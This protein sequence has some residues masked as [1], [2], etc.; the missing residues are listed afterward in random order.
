MDRDYLVMDYVP[1]KDLSNLMT[2]ARLKNRFLD[3]RDVLSWAGQLSEALSYLHSQE[4]PIVHRDIKPSNLKLTP[5]G[6]IK[7][8]DFGLVKI[9]AS[10]DEVTTDD[11]G[12]YIFTGLTAGTYTVSVSNEDYDVKP[13]EVEKE[14]TNEN[15]EDVDFVMSTL[16]PLVYLNI[17]P[18]GT[19]GTYINIFGLN[20]GEDPE[21]AGNTSTVTIGQ[22]DVSLTPGVYIGGT[23]P[24]K[25]IKCEIYSW[26][27]WKIVAIA[28]QAFGLFNVWVVQPTEDGGSTACYISEPIISNIY[29]SY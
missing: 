21:E 26:E 6:V 22:T 13:E 2:A 19:Q 17:P 29:F 7:L 12:A 10:S 16:C 27:F 18:V 23:N 11:N 14:I 8:V 25:W 5:D 24:E 15:I 20:F 9:L 3:E 4:P 1:G 28:P